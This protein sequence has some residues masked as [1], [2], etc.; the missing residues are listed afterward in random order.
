MADSPSATFS[1]VVPFFNEA[2]VAFEVVDELCVELARGALAWE[3]ILVDD[4]SSDGTRDELERAQAKWPQC[5]I[6]PL[7]RNAGQGAALSRGFETATGAIVGMMDGDGQ[8]V[9]ADLVKMPPFL[10]R[11][12][13][14]VGV[15]TPRHD[16]WTRRAMSRL[17]NR[18]RRQL[19]HDGVSD[20]GCAVKVFR[21]EVIKSFLPVTMLN[22][23]IPAFAVAGG[24]RV[25]EAPVAHRPRRAGASKYGGTRLLWRPCLDMLAIAWV[26][27]RLAR[28]PPTA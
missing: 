17:A 8:N 5:R 20:A 22:P 4:G 18:V 3:A 1:V 19:L 6:V 13:V 10:D 12:D 11:V 2:A 26:L 7:S 21:R 16:A 24:F 27:R 14:V 25:A 15:R 23:F 9:P 28:V